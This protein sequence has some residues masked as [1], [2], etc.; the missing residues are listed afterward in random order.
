MPALSLS[1]VTAASVLLV[2]R[3]GPCWGHSGPRFPVVM[4]E[5]SATLKCTQGLGHDHEYWYRQDLGH[6]LRLIH[7][8]VAAPTPEKEDMPDRWSISRPNTE[9]FPLML[10]SA[11]HSQTSVYFCGSSYCTALRGHLLSVQKDRWPTCRLRASEASEVAD[12]V[13]AV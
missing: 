1:A 4:T 5:Q 10:E 3:G 9:H 11:N 12:H 2:H 7:Y 6:G 13:P 8:S